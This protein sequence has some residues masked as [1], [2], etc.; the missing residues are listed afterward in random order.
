MTLAPTALPIRLS[1]D[2]HPGGSRG[3]PEWR[4]L[5]ECRSYY[6]PSPSSFPHWDAAGRGRIHSSGRRLPQ[7]ADLWHSLDTVASAT[8]V[9]SRLCPGGFVVCVVRNERDIVAITERS[10]S[11]SRV[12]VSFSESARKT[13]R[14]SDFRSWGYL[15][16][17][18]V[19][20]RR[21]SHPKQRCG[22]E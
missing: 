9:L 21:G 22:G 14:Q 3:S 15:D 2:T 1:G 17:G 8:I 11:R 5:L 19:G 4:W 7:V 18:H 10:L 6:L 12:A 16:S 20:R 13:S